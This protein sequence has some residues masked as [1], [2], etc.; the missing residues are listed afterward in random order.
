M[1]LRGEPQQYVN[2]HFQT[3]AHAICKWKQ[4]NKL[5]QNSWQICTIKTFHVKN[6]CSLDTTILYA[7]GIPTS[8]PWPTP[9]VLED[10]FHAYITVH[11]PSLTCPR[12]KWLWYPSN[13]C[14][15]I[16]KVERRV[17]VY[18]TRWTLGRREALSLAVS[19]RSKA[20]INISV[21]VVSARCNTLIIQ[22]SILM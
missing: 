18:T 8:K 1:M 13:E 16:P 17:R 21:Q 2:I 14:A 12:P 6:P 22:M 11:F 9:L 15:W 4:D 3:W 10:N 5:D 19:I 7:C 20:T